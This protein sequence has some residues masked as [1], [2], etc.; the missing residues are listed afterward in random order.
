M[1]KIYWLTSCSGLYIIQLLRQASKLDFITM[2]LRVWECKYVFYH[3]VLDECNPICMGNKLLLFSYQS[4]LDPFVS[5]L[6]GACYQK[7]FIITHQCGKQENY[8]STYLFRIGLGSCRLIQNVWWV[9][10]NSW[11][12]E[13]WGTLFVFR[14]WPGYKYTTQTQTLI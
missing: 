3:G 2:K 6:G 5:N 11:V 10:Q 1:T 9:L 4:I 14:I 13:P 7:H 8:I 12:T